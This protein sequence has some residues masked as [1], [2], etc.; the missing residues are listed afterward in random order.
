LKIDFFIAG[1]QK[2]ATTKVKEMINGNSNVS[3]HELEEMTYFIDEEFESEAFDFIP[4]YFD[5][6]SSLKKLGAKSAS[7]AI[8][9]SSL[10]RL[11][12]H[13]SSCKIILVLRN[14][15]KRAYSAFWYCR[16]MGWEDEGE[17]S[18][19]IDRP[20]NSYPKGMIRR[21][22]DY[23]GQS[24]YAK[25][26]KVVLKYFPSEQV[27]TYILEEDFADIDV[28]NKDL[29]SFLGVP[30]ENKNKKAMVNSSAM[31]NFLFLTKFLRRK[32]VLSSLI[33]GVMPL[34][35]VKFVRKLKEKLV[36]LNEVEF[37]KP[38]MDEDVLS[39]L[40]VF[41]ENKNKE[42]ELLLNRTIKKW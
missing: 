32:S 16:R 38:E 13:N 20:R 33:K 1:F 15:V 10:I 34:R 6:V 12:N 18:V 7:M 17:F 2:A 27:K 21:S 25:H 39:K 35:V 29:C 22:C 3:M 37:S 28:L 40:E 11:K 4:Q 19:A 42:L 26:I 24:Y 9:E 30:F 5:E 23:L 36:K 14:P 8:S 31:P 41:F